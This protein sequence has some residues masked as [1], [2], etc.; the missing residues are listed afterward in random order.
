M[1]DSG[2]ALADIDHR[3]RAPRSVPRTHELEKHGQARIRTPIAGPCE[4]HELAV[5]QV[6]SDGRLVSTTPT[7]ANHLLKTAEV[8]PF[9]AYALL[10]ARTAFAPNTV[11]R[12][13]L[14]IPPYESITSTVRHDG[15]ND[16]MLGEP[17]RFLSRFEERRHAYNRAKI[18]DLLTAAVL[19]STRGKG[20]VLLLL[21]DGI[22]STP[23][24][25]ALAHGGI[26]A[27]CVTY[28]TSGSQTHEFAASIATKY[29]HEHVLVDV[30]K[31]RL[32]KL[33][34]VFR[35]LTFP[36][37]DFGSLGYAHLVTEGLSSP[38]TV[39][40]DGSGNDRYM[41]PGVS[42]LD[43]F[44][45]PVRRSTGVDPYLSLKRKSLTPAYVAYNLFSDVDRPSPAHEGPLKALLM[46][47]YES[48]SRYLNALDTRSDL[49]TRRISAHQYNNNG[50]VFDLAGLLRVRFP[51]SDEHLRDYFFHAEE[52]RRDG[53]SKVFL[54]RF[55]DDTENYSE[56]IRGKRGFVFPITS[57]LAGSSD[58]HGEQRTPAGLRRAMLGA[59]LAQ[60]WQ[61]DAWGL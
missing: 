29:G 57:L 21:S 20:D 43:R 12:N 50:R 25:R 22:D 9:R 28:A 45:H 33:L 24:A 42:R 53:A 51:W 41:G 34:A 32:E 49:F 3:Q 37:V 59:T 7:Q 26:R 30:L 14:W 52:K 61:P 35:D 1:T 31:L 11:F 2:V 5:V 60:R 6:L 4:E 17:Y 54:R 40:L 38:T 23:L 47:M 55:L 56:R 8:C 10:R 18:E 27:R 16:H 46:S 39:V 58:M 13:L 48:R 15:C 36:T 44:L 19:R